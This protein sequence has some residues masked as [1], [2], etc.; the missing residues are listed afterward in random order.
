MSRVTANP[1]TVFG[2]TRRGIVGRGD[3]QGLAVIKRMRSPP[4][5]PMTLGNMPICRL[6]GA[7]LPL[8]KQRSLWHKRDQA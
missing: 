3:K 1:L 8:A 6:P 4:V 5:D 7:Q 2:P